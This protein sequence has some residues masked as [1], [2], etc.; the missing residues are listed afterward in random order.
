MARKVD[1][2]TDHDGRQ[3]RGLQTE[4]NPLLLSSNLNLIKEQ[5]KNENPYLSTSTLR[6]NDKVTKRLE[7]G[8]K[9][10]EKGEVSSQ[11]ERQ[12]EEQRLEY[13]RQKEQEILN[14]IRREKEQ[15]ETS[16]KIARG[17]LPDTKVGED[18]YIRRIEDVPEVE[19]WDKPYLDDQLNVLPK[20][21]GGYEEE[22]ESD[23]EDEVPS[24]KYVHHP[25][26][27]KV[28]NAKPTT[29]VFLTKK[30]Q[31]KIRRNRRKVEREEKETRIKMGLDPKPKPKV[32]LANMMSVYENN[33]NI[34]DPTQWEHTVIEQVEQRKRTHLE[35]NMIRHEE[36]VKRRKESKKVEL[37]TDN[38]CKVFRF[39]SLAN[40]K[41][42]FKLSTNSKQ[43]AL[44]GACLRV[45]DQGEGMIIVVGSEKSCKFFER[46]VLER[47][48]WDEPFRDR[49][50]DTLIET[51]NNHAEKVW[52]GYL[53]CSKF[54][55]W[56]M[57]VCRDDLEL[58]NT[59]RQFDAEH[60]LTDVSHI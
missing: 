38:C 21:Q 48:K 25:V 27:I 44:R 20:Y 58:K 53:E 50:T 12:R 60:F 54:P 34:T 35:T 29:K 18:K 4:I 7:R 23:E 28:H 8:L 39:K 10:H 15:A 36:A 42:R 13:E 49:A 56:F 47:I 6:S 26:P 41:I 59:L 9:F 5:F 17:E 51:P 30:E 24:I 22:S 32:K 2:K 37:S 19:W 55:R 40:P 45:G 33:Q 3:S 31:K 14:K 46:L 43:L 52:Q 11:I 57:K 1:K 16:A